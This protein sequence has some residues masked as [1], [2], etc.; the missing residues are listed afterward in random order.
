MELTIVVRT[1]NSEKTIHRLLEKLRNVQV[2]KNESVECLFVDNN[3][4]DRTATYIQSVLS[5][6]PFASRLVIESKPGAAATRIRGFY[7]AQGDYVAFLDDD[8]LPRENWV[9]EIC[10]AIAEYPEASAISGRI[11]L[12]TT[13]PVPQYAKP[14]LVFYAIVDRGDQPFRYDQTPKRVMPPGAGLIVRRADA[15]RLLNQEKLRL[16]GP[17][18]NGFHLKGEDIELLIRLQSQ[19]GQIWYCPGIVIDHAV[20]MHRFT[21]DYLSSFLK[22]VARP[23]HYHRL[24]RYHRCWWLM[25]SL[26]HSTNDLRHWLVHL[27][28]YDGSIDWQLRYEFLLHLLISPVYTVSILV[29]SSQKSDS[30]S[31]SVSDESLMPN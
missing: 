25:A 8:N 5:H 19:G 24:L 10:R 4:Q 6:L 13:A 16:A 28:R 9:L 12:L 18:G 21:P 29:S 15:L 26:I 1:Y 14:Y 23:R 11:R 31:L 20:S 22:A 17:V 3:S 2:P 30:S 27:L 7:E